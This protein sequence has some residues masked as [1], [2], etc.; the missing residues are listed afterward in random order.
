[1]KLIN[2]IKTARR[3]FEFHDNNMSQPF[4]LAYDILLHLSKNLNF[5]FETVEPKDGQWG[6]STENEL[7]FNGI[8]GELQR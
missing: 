5:Q 7:D 1:M 3:Y 4:G 8:V 6:I 2:C